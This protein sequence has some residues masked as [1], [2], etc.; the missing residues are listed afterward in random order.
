MYYNS[1]N[2]LDLILLYFSFIW[3]FWNTILIIKKNYITYVVVFLRP[4]LSQIIFHFFNGS[5]LILEVLTLYLGVTLI[6]IFIL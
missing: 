6:F 2:D 3:K 5:N 1:F 4:H